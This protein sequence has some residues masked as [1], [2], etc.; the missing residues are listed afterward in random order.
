MS[1]IIEAFK[2]FLKYEDRAY[3]FG[4]EHDVL[5]V[6]Y[7]PSKIAK[8]DIVALEKLGFHANFGEEH[9]YHFV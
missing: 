6:W 7:N 9:F 3:P 2:I 5:Y 4:C 8:K 1:S